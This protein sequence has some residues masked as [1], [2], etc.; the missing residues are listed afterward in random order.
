MRCFPAT[1]FFIRINCTSTFC[2]IMKSIWEFK[3]NVIHEAPHIG[4]N[5]LLRSDCGRL[6]LTDRLPMA[7]QKLPNDFREF[8]KLLNDHHRCCSCNSC[9][10]H[11][12]PVEVISIISLEHDYEQGANI[13]FDFSFLFMF[14]QFYCICYGKGEAQ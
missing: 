11:K 8:L 12:F 5:A 10:Y 9:L 1:S 2:I 14:Y 13:I 6:I 4:S 3:R 7:K